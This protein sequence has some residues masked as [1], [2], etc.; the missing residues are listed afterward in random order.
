M[1]FRM[2]SFSFELQGFVWDVVR[3]L[4]KINTC[5]SA[6]QDLAYCY[7]AVILHT[8]NKCCNAI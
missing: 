6:L 5:V 4:T 3:K 2:M 7:K 8:Y 1:Y